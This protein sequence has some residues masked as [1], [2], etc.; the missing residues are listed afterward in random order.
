[1]SGSRTLILEKIRSAVRGDAQTPVEEP[2]FSLERPP[3]SDTVRLTGE[4]AITHFIQMAQGAFAS[5]DRI[6]S[7]QAIPAAVLT[8]L[9]AQ[10]LVEEIHLCQTA[11]FA[12]LDWGPV[13]IS[14]VAICPVMMAS[15]TLA[16]AGV[17]ESGSIVMCSAAD[18]PTTLNY[19]PDHHLVVLPC[20]RLM[21]TKEDVFTSILANGTMPRT[22]NFIT[23]PSRTADIEQV[24]QLGAHGPR[25]LHILLVDEWD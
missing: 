13:A 4:E 25:N 10:G 22:V 8:Y 5:V 11:A 7:K 21:G 2:K 19:L 12:D 24:I 15:M 1:M 3:L 16:T 6:A 23:G 17:L 14:S 20:K 18:A 9:K